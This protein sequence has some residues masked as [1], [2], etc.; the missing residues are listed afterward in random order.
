LALEPL[1]GS[2]RIRWRNLVG[3]HT[4]GVCQMPDREWSAAIATA[5]TSAL[6]AASA[7]S[8]SR[9]TPLFRNKQLEWAD[10]RLRALA[11]QDEKQLA[12]QLFS[13]S[14][15]CDIEAAHRRARNLP[16][17]DDARSFSSTPE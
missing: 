13:V 14:S 17:W 6:R 1:E 12:R 5:N 9:W 11:A 3:H 7:A 15:I 10:E 16:D 8:R 4:Q 2:A